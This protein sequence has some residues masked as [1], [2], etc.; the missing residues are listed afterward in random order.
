MEQQDAKEFVVFVEMLLRFIHEF[1]SMI[2][3]SETEGE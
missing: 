2:P 3:Q 1:P